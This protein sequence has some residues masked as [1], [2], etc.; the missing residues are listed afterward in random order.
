MKKKSISILLAALMIGLC[1]A[2]CGKKNEET[3]EAPTTVEQTT[4]EPAEVSVMTI[5]DVPET[6]EEALPEGMMYSYLTGKVVPV[7]VGRKRPV[8]FQIDNER[9]AQPQNGVSTA[10]IVY[11]VPI[12]ANEVRLTAI[13]Q[14]FDDTDRIGP[15]RSARSYHPGIV[16]EY[17]GIFFHHGHSD[18]ALPY[19]DDE[20]CDD[21]E[22]IANSGWPAVFESSDHS[23]GH[24]IFT[25]QEKVMKQVE[26]LGFRTEMKQDYTYKFQFAKTSEK[27]VPEGGQ[28]ANKVSIGYTQN[29]PYFEYNA[30]D[31]RYYRYAFDKAH[32]DQANDKQVAVDN[33]IVEYCDYNLEWDKNT[34]N[35]HTVG[36]GTGVFITAGKAVPITWEKADYWENTHYYYQSGE[37]IT[38]NQGQ[39]WVCIVLPSM[40]GEIT[41]E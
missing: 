22:G 21:L 41:V 33:V 15:L 19:L 29:H 13:F 24:N 30:E 38:L 25:N 10:E 14:S 27:I 40:T 23:A 18:L 17:D 28:D 39:T 11:E 4:K 12:E 37:E 3:T 32:I 6:T 8:A 16:A 7:E 9:R 34:K 1:A 20:R 26:K 35:I 2:G 36:T 31:G 5:A